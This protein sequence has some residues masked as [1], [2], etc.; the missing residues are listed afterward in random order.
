MRPHYS[1]QNSPYF[2]FSDS[3]VVHLLGSELHELQKMLDGLQS[4][5]DPTQVVQA[6]LLRREVMFLQFDAAVR[7]LIR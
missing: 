3:N 6:L 2:T 7:H 5:Q 4:P 1:S